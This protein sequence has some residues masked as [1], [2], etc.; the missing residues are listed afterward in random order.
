FIPALGEATLS[1]VAIK[2][3]SKTGLCLKISPFRIG[4]SLEQVLPDF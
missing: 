1:G 3:D 4:G 2:T